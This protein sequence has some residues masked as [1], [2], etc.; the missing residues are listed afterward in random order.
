MKKC[1]YTVET[2]MEAVEVVRTNRLSLHRAADIYGIGKSTINDHII[3]RVNKVGPGPMPY[4]G[5]NLEQRL[6]R[7]LIK[8][9]CIG[10]GQSKNDLFDCIQV[11]VKRLK[12]ETKF[13]DGHPREQ[14]YKLYLKCFPDLKLHQAQLLSCQHAGISHNALN[15]WYH[16]LF[17]YL[18]ETGNLSILNEPLQIFNA[19]ETRFPMAPW[20]TKVLAGKG[21]PNVYQQGSSDTSQITT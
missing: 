7:W 20:P 4:I 19:D 10:Y 1:N 8:M 13:F 11:I 17:E 14:W 16:E 3:K 6:Y 5:D 9:V 2:L 15:V 12:W 21:D 18:E